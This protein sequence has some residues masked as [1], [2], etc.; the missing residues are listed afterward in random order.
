GAI[1]RTAGAARL[2][3]KDTIVLADFANSTGDPIFDDTLR[4]GLSSQLEQSPFLNLLSEKQITQTLAL[5]TQP[6]GTRLTGNLANAAC[7]RTSSAATV[8]GSISK[9]GSEYVLGLRAA[10]CR[11]GDLLY[12]D[13]ITT[14]DKEQVLYALGKTATKMRQKLGESLPSIQQYDVPLQ[15]VTT[16]SLEAL[17]AYS[18]G[19]QAMGAK[20]DFPA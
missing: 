9:L 1:R 12:E 20:A 5:I 7:Q 10:D 17:K 15:K 11:S 13:Q 16:P 6:A 2:T 4:Q 19:E 8:E 3:D 14:K 18:L